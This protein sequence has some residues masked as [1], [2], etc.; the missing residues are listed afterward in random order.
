M[1]ALVGQFH[2]IVE[3]FDGGVAAT[4]I[5]VVD[6]RGPIG[7]HEHGGVA[8]HLDAACRVASMMGVGGGRVGPDNLAAHS[9]GE[10]DP[11]TVYLGTG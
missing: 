9:P 4:I 6:E 2:E 5:E 11:L 1:R 10:P 3:V 8:T 7:G